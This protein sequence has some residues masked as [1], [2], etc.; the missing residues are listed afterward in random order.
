MKQR[1]CTKCKGL[2]EYIPPNG[3]TKADIVKCHI[4]SATGILPKDYKIKKDGAR[5][6]KPKYF[7]KDAG[8][9]QLKEVEEV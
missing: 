2:G 8:L 3:M 7:R 5:T 4:C 6:S 1:K 9:D